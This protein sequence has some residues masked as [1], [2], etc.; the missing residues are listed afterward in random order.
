[1]E[2]RHLISKTGCV[3]ISSVPI[4]CPMMQGNSISEQ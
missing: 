2:K 1:M 4:H 3:F